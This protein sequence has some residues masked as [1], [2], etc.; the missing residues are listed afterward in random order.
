MLNDD[1]KAHRLRPNPYNIYSSDMN[2]PVLYVNVGK[3]HGNLTMRKAPGIDECEI[4]ENVLQPFT[5]E[6]INMHVTP[7]ARI[8]PCD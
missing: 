4:L 6:L 7:W 5:R 2:K 8:G 1:A 3:M